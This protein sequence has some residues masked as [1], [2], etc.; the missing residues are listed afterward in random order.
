MSFPDEV[1]ELDVRTGAPGTVEVEVAAP[2][3]QVPEAAHVPDRRVEPHVEVLPGHVRNLEPEVRS[4]ARDVPVLQAGIE[5]LV[6]LVGDLGLHR[7]AAVAPPAGEPPPQRRLE[8]RQAHEVVLRRSQLGLLPRQDRHRIGKIGGAVGRAADLAVVTVLIRCPAARTRSLDV[9]IRQEHLLH[10]VVCLG[11]V[12]ARDVPGLLQPRVDQLGARAILRRVGG[13]VVVER[14]RE[15]PKVGPVFF[16]DRLDERL[17]SHSLL[18]GLEHDRSA[19]SVV[20]ADVGAAVTERP[21]ESHPDVGLD[22]LHHVP[23]VNRAVCVR[24]RARHQERAIRCGHGIDSVVWLETGRPRTLAPSP[25]GV[26][27]HE[28]SGWR[29]WWARRRARTWFRTSRRYASPPRAR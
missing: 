7:G 1:V 28:H 8:V 15:V 14:D 20:G 9:A 6:E 17:R 21:L 2:R 10:R 13:V 19:V 12:L 25:G 27:S 23:D 18:L 26:T 11:D 24:Q 16:A 22:V 3:A 4:V 5:P 29:W